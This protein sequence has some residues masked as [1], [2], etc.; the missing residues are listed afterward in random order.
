MEDDTAHRWIHLT[1]LRA[2]RC[3][4]KAKCYVDHV[5]VYRSWKP[6]DVLNHFSYKGQLIDGKEVWVDNINAL[7]VFSP[8]EVIPK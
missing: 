4:F 2:Q 7:N 5:V 1:G 6:G 3:G 8:F